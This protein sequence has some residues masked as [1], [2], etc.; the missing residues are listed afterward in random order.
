MSSE[1]DNEAAAARLRIRVLGTF[2]QAPS[3]ATLALSAANFGEVMEKLG[4]TCQAKVTDRFGAGGTRT[5]DFVPRRPKSFQ[6]TDVVASVPVLASLRALAEKLGG[7]AAPSADETVASVREL[8]G[9][10]VLTAAVTKAFQPDAPA[11]PSVDDVLAGGVRPAAKSAIDAVVRGMKPASAGPAKGARA[12]RRVLE[13]AL[14]ATAADVLRD[15][16]VARLESAWRGLKLLLDQCPTAA[17]TSVEVI[18]VAPGRLLETLSANLPAEE[19]DRPDLFVVADPVDDPVVLRSLADAAE[20]ALAPVIVAASPQLMGL[21]DATAIG[22]RAEE[23]TGGL[24]EDWPELRAD[25][26]SRWLCVVVNRAVVAAEGHGDARRVSLASPSLA[27]AA[28]LAASFRDTRSFAR[29]LGAPGAL[30]A[31]ATHELAGGRDGGM[32]VPTEVFLPI[33]TQQRLA[34]FGILALGSGRNSPKLMLSAIPTAR[35]SAD[36]VPLPAQILTGRIV[37]FASWVRDQI[38]PS[39]SD[40]DAATLFEQAAQVFLF[41]GVGEGA[42]LRAGVGTHEGTRMVEV[43]VNAKAELAAIPFQ[44]TFTLP[45]QR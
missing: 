27:L 41:E 44:M 19:V 38:P 3:G 40:Q 5:I 31:P 17:A 14:F 4:L 34:S 12:A 39:S 15:P 22:N 10:G 13:D 9:E 37:R 28:M 1:Q 20:T 23:P 16:T 6:L 43:A 24:P 45:L 25:E 18:D 2:T 32:T 11:A 36:A 30:D 29:I 33:A 7:A 42:T 8:V 35:G 21:T 26:A